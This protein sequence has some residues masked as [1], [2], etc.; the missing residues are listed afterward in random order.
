MRRG[1]GQV[2]RE[3]FGPIAQIGDVVAIRDN[4]NFVT[5]DSVHPFYVVTEILTAQR[6][7]TLNNFA[8]ILGLWCQTAAFGAPY[9]GDA[10]C[11]AGINLN[12]AIAG[13]GNNALIP[14]AFQ[15]QKR[16][17]AQCRYLVKALPDSNGAYVRAIDDFAIQVQVPPQTPRS[18]QQTTGV[19]SAQSQGS[20]P[21]DAVQS[22]SPGNNVAQPSAPSK[23]P[24]DYVGRDEFWLY[25]PDRKG[26]VTIYNNNPAATVQGAIGIALGMFAFNLV[27]LPQDNLTGDWFLGQKVVRP[28]S[29]NLDDVIVIPWGTQTAP[30]GVGSAT[31]T[32][33]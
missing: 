10:A 15:L 1:H 17:F 24:F 6:V 30:P 19:M 13:K 28:A 5:D 2:N 22:P 26:S 12:I 23:D 7:G 8:G 14:N 20:D 33:S 25:G 18:T 31:Q 21:G 11:Q 29:L 32:T 4:P 9:A 3:E 16:Q 27:P